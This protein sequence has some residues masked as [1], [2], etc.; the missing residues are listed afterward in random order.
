MPTADIVV[1]VPGK[2]KSGVKNFKT[3]LEPLTGKELLELLT[4]KDHESE[5]GGGCA[6]EEVISEAD[7]NSL[8]DRSDL[9]GKWQ[10]GEGE[11]SGGGVV[12]VHVPTVILLSLVVFRLITVHTV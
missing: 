8:L 1:D 3:S 2:F 11:N 9:N 5:V 6:E 10:E 7:L 4:S 12:L